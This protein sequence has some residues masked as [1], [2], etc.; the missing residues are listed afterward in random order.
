MKRDVGDIFSFE[1]RFLKGFIT[2]QYLSS[3]FWSGNLL[4]LKDDSL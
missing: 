4:H 1:V 3:R 2:P